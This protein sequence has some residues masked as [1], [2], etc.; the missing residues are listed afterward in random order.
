[1]RTTCLLSI[2]YFGDGSRDARQ[3]LATLVTLC[4]TDSE[5]GHNL[6]R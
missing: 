5:L 3:A 1:M 4:S 6:D 2:G